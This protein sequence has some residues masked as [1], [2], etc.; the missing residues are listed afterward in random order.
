ML[1]YPH[2]TT[3]KKSGDVVI[4]G[5]M[6]VGVPF[7]NNNKTIHKGEM[8]ILIICITASGILFKMEMAG[9]TGVLC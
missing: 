8:V 7:I 5:T 3:H 9:L 1:T 2:F 6:P 4:V